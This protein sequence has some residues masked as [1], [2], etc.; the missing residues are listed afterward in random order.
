[1]AEPSQPRNGTPRW[2]RVVLVLSLGL[3]LAVAGLAIGSAYKWR[4]EGGPPRSFDLSL[5]PL[6]RALAPEDRRAVTE[7][8]RRRGDGEQP[9]FRDIRRRSE[10]L[11]ALLRAEE[12]DAQ[13]FADGLDE[14]RGMALAFQ[15][16]GQV[17][18]IERISAMS[19]EARRAL[20]DRFE[21]QSRRGARPGD[22]PDRTDG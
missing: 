14:I 6:S 11:L 10:A 18:L 3:N 16:V 20:A 4:S 9:D 19:P 12:F 13:A 8:I 2:L 7:E 17:A 1:M 21:D 15:K 5:G 22:R